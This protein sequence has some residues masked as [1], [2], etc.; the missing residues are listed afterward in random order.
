[1]LEIPKKDYKQLAG[2]EFGKATAFRTK[3]TVYNKEMTVLFTDKHK[4][5][6]RTNRRGIQI[7]LA[8]RACL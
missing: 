5:D 3:A 8:C 2:I 6:Q 7:S 1:L 4:L